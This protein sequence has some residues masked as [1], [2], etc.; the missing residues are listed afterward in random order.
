MG[1]PSTASE[2]V[3]GAG[4]SSHSSPAMS[5]LRRKKGHSDNNNSRDS[6]ASADEIGTG[7]DLSTAAAT[8][9]IGKA[10][11]L[12][13]LGVDNVEEVG[14]E[15]SIHTLSATP[16]RRPRRH[17]RRISS[18]LSFKSWSFVILLDLPFGVAL[19]GVEVT[20]D[21]CRIRSYSAALRELVG[22]SGA[23]TAPGPR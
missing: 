14:F 23:V 13:E 15:N 12:R 16:L 2:L 1:L 22:V 5:I 6:C 3:A 19:V 11:R 8:S 4:I 9:S 21:L 20:S 7:E 10:R 18:W 17:R